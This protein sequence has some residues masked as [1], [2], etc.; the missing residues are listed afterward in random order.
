MYG[1]KAAATPESIV[2]DGSYGIR[3]GHGGKA[4]A[5]IE[6]MVSDGSHGILHALVGK[7]LGY[8]Y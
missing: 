3:N 5:S 4:A 6:S 2:S 7:L 1:V 8:N